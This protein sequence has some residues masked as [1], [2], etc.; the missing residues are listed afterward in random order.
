MLE[1]FQLAIR[2]QVNWPL[3]WLSRSDTHAEFSMGITGDA[4]SDLSDFA[5]GLER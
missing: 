4:G 5:H 1:I 3:R 2:L